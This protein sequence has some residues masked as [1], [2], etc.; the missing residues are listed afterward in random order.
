MAGVDPSTFPVYA[1]K[2]LIFFVGGLTLVLVS[3][4]A[5]TIC[6]G[7]VARAGAEEAL[8]AAGVLQKAIF[9]SA[10]F[11]CIATDASGIIQIFNVGAERML[12]YTAAEVVNKITPADLHDPQEVIA[13]ATG[14]SREFG[15]SIAPGFEALVFKAARGIEDI[16]EL[17]KV[18]KDGTR[19]PAIV[20]V[21][22]LRDAQNA[23]IG[24]LLIGTDNT[25]RRQVDDALRKSETQLQT[26]VENISEAVVVSDL[27]GQLLHFNHAALNMLG[28]ATLEEGRRNYSQLADTFELSGV[29]GTAWT[30]DQWPM[31]RI[32]RGEKL[33]GLEARMRRFGTEW[34]HIYSF[35][36]TIARDAGGTPVMAVV[37]FSDITQRRRAESAALRLAA[38]VESSVDAV[39]GKDLNS[40][41]TS[42]NA[43]AERMFGYSAAEM[44]GQRITRIIPA[45]HQNDEE[46]I[47]SSIRRGE[48]VEHFETERLRKDGSL[49]CISV[50]VSPIKDSH[51][52]VIGA[53]KVA[54]DITDRKRA[55]ARF[56]RLVD[57]NVQGV[58][59]WNA[60][61]KISDAN[62]AFLR[63]VGYA[64]DDLTAGRLNWRKLSSPE[65]ADLDQRAMD[66]LAATGV[67]APYEKEYIR[68]DGSP[69]RV[70]VGAAS[71]E[72]NI[73]EGVCF[74]LD[75]TESHRNES[76]AL[77]LAAIVDS[78]VDA[79]IGKDLNGIITHWNDAAERMFGYSA[80]EIVGRSIALIIPAKHRDDEKRFLSMIK[81]G[82]RIEHFETERLRKDGSLISISLTIS[83][84]RDSG[85]RVIG[86]SKVVR[87]ITER[88][89][90]QESLRES[91]ERF[92][93]LVDGVHEYALILL[94]REG[95]V[96]SWNA[97]AERVKGYKAEE[98][99]GRSF[100]VLYPP[101][102]V[103]A[104][105]PAMELKL[106]TEQGRWEDEGWRV[107]A[108]GTRFWATVLIT[109]LK[110]AAGN[111]RGFSKLTRDITERKVAEELLLKAGALQRAIFNSANF[112]SIATDAKGVIQIFNVGA[113]RMLGYTAAEV[114]NKITPAEISDPQEV[115]ARAQALSLELGT[116]I[117][118][119][120]EA[121]VFKASRGIE[122]IYE[123]TYIRRDGSRFPALVS[124]TALRDALGGI[125]G[126]LLIG[127][128]NTA[129]IEAEGKI[130]RWNIELEQ[131]I[132]DRTAELAESN[133]DLEAFTYSVSHDLRAPLRAIDG[134]SRILETE[135]MSN[136]P[137][138]AK[139]FLGLVRSNVQQ[140]GQLVED[141]LLLCRHGRQAIATRMVQPEDIAQ[142][143]WKDLNQWP[144]GRAIEFTVQKLDPCRADP[145][146]L[147]QV[148]VNLLSNAIKFTRAREN[149]QITV[150]AEKDKAGEVVYFVKDNGVGFDMRYVHK[151]FGVFQRLHRAE[152]YDG[153]GVG[154]AIVHRIIKRHGGRVWA[155]SE[156][157]KGAVISFTLG[158]EKT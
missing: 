54:R 155:Q 71:F 44:V 123:L 41:V 119:G 141:L 132:A 34:Q 133:S 85:G 5:W 42:W 110:D 104:G 117:K 106:A 35:G 139:R 134:F 17:T 19:F 88:M 60:E 20:S 129:R 113:E 10:N 157:G 53:S 158:S 77:L 55:E 82:E 97:G 50:T 136:L 84:I 112:S 153:T 68:K 2:A 26:I 76:A 151:L 135:H 152:D 43:A 37:T 12:G 56:R 93:L 116:P 1:L 47:L 148:F 126:Y 109:A 140:M 81:R 36:G 128:D 16:Y 90:A 96:V 7:G 13:R 66:E 101:E 146:L 94:D 23:I 147:K 80:S 78:S 57:S 102:D 28:Y 121:L 74:V 22:A 51:G 156:P 15:T 154:L 64:R 73:K 8:L 58:L 59:F 70:L 130:S 92:R 120:F 143:A 103:A 99:I 3:G 21:T 61:G 127:T 79:V 131:R 38:I 40:I 33:N 63:I 45:N 24:Y 30:V 145:G 86:A 67:C 87:D 124:V 108:D 52:K 137:P 75:R 91:E 150:G 138:E 25:A 18:R 100:S 46:Q 69:V 49:V 125:I 62:D 39:I 105:K 111:L 149:T 14:L 9:N 48:R 114:M 11:S 27:N 115:I 89:K 29:D 83:P 65:Y 32:L 31:A 122:D 144:S 107:R 118:P 4:A 98:I 72:D 95:N 142:Q 6:R